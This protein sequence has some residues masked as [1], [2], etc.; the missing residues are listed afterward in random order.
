VTTLSDF[1]YPLGIGRG[2]PTSDDFVE[3]SPFM[4]WSPDA[5]Y[6]VV[7]FEV[8]ES[9]LLFPYLVDTVT[10]TTTPIP[11]PKDAT[12]QPLHSWPGAWTFAWAD[13]HTLLLFYG[14]NVLNQG[15]SGPTYSYDV[16]TKTL[17]QLPGITDAAE[18]VVR[19]STLFYLSLTPLTTQVGEDPQDG[20]TYYSGTALLH[21][22]DLKTQTELGQPVTLGATLAFTGPMT[23]NA[24]AP[25][26]DVS[27]G[28]KLLVYEPTAVDKTDPTRPFL[29]TQQLVAANVD[30][31]NARTLSTTEGGPYITISP[32][33]RFVAFTPPHLI[34]TLS[35]KGDGYRT[36][37]SNGAGDVGDGGPKWLPDSS[38]FDVVD[39][40]P[41]NAMAPVVSRYL[42]ST[43]PGTD[44]FVPGTVVAPEAEALAVLS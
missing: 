44:G 42:L 35:L 36:Y 26:W 23:S 24:G 3:L 15:S 43:P 6:L 41:T 20:Y 40:S 39:N 11:V 33:S 32:D 37:G 25:P 1:H 30:G 22:Y 27:A 28:G 7:G 34:V 13:T 14:G 29:T 31:S 18:G 16:T 12:N 2:N 19:C 9:P 38:G 10:H 17:S 4:A 8:I 21:R 5:R